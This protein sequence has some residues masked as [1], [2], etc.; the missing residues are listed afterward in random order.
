MTYRSLVWALCLIGFAW[1]IAFLLTKNRREVHR[2]P[3]G[4]PQPKKEKPLK[5]NLE[6]FIN[7]ELSVKDPSSLAHPDKLQAYWDAQNEDDEED[8]S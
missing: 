7:G 6:S 2:K 4:E 5:E 8:E 1:I 3:L